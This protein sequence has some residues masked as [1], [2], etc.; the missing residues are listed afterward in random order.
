MFVAVAWQTLLVGF[1]ISCLQLDSSLTDLLYCLGQQYARSRTRTF[2]KT[3]LK[4]EWPQPRSDG[5]T[6]RSFLWGASRKP[7]FSWWKEVSPTGTGILS[8]TLPLLF[9]CSVDIMLEGKQPS[10]QFWGR[11]SGVSEKEV[12][13]SVRPC[14]LPETATSALPQN[15]YYERKRKPLFG[16]VL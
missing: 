8:S 14:W 16:Q 7:L 11:K 10:F 1:T 6:G 5:D 9:A 3:P 4:L 13:R 15:F 12:R 2:F